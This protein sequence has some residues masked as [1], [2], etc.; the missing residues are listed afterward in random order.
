MAQLGQGEK[1]G[2]SSP[3][4]AGPTIS[5]RRW[6]QKVA[7]TH[8]LPPPPAAAPQIRGAGSCRCQRLVDLPILEKLVMHQFRENGWVKRLR[9]RGRV[10][11]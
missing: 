8:S 5:S 4:T 10:N 6:L 9:R 3:C 1:G 11:G 7:T 2:V